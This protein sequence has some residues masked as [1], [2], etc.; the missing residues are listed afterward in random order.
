MTGLAVG[1]EVDQL[2]SAIDGL[3]QGRPAKAEPRHRQALE[4]A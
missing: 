4:P 3:W 2:A 1:S